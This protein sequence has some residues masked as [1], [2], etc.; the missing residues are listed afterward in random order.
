MARRNFAAGN[1]ERRSDMNI[2]ELLLDTLLVKDDTIITIVADRRNI[3]GNWFE[4]HILDIMNT[5][6]EVEF[7]IYDTVEN[8]IAIKI[9]EV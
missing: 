8:S 5:E 7:F 3:R 6:R 1:Y 9:K 2:K 4:D